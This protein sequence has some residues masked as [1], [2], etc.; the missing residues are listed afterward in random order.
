MAEALKIAQEAERAEEE[1]MMRKALEESQKI[2]QRE[3]AVADEEDEMIRQAI[4]MSQK[5]EA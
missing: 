5:E 1:E 3:K 2:E 4:E